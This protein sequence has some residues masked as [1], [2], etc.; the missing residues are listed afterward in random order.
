MNPLPAAR[1]VFARTA[2]GALLPG[3][4]AVFRVLFFYLPGK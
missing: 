3:D 2:G 4:Y 1:A